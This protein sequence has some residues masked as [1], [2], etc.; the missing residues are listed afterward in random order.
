[1]FDQ[2]GIWIQR[3]FDVYER[4]VRLA[5]QRARQRQRS[6]E[7]EIVRINRQ[8]IKLQLVDDARGG[9]SLEGNPGASEGGRSNE[10]PY[11]DPTLTGGD[12]PW[13]FLP[14]QKI[15]PILSKDVQDVDVA[16]MMGKIKG[17]FNYQV[18]D[19]F[20]RNEYRLKKLFVRREDMV[21]EMSAL[22]TLVDEDLIDEY[23]VLIREKFTTFEQQFENARREAI[24]SLQPGDQPPPAEELLRILPRQF[25]VSN[26]FPDE[27]GDVRGWPRYPLVNLAEQIS[28]ALSTQDVVQ[29]VGPRED[30]IA[31]QDE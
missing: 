11:G 4:F 24:Q 30:F 14:D 13:R 18:S 3:Q 17:P 15:G 28:R 21:L 12:Q 27:I 23:L 2:L 8:I 1:M 26:L 20:Q 31:T 16:L 19:R 25:K 9:T 5:S 6:L 7:A 29:R 10:D 22:T